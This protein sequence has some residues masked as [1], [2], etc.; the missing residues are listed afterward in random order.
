M[1]T[2][3]ENSRLAGVD[4]TS[5]RDVWLKKLVY[6]MHTVPTALAPVVVGVG[7]AAGDDVFAL[8]SALVVF[9]FGWLVQLGGVLADNYFNLVRYH[10]DAE[11]PA[12]VYAVDN[13][14]IELGEIKRVT[15]AVFVL[16]A[17][18]A[19]Y[20]VAV[21][22]VPVIVVGVASVAV[23]VFYSLEL[24]DV[25]LHDLYFFLFFGP[26]S[27]GGTYYMQAVSHLPVSFPTWLPLGTLPLAVVAAGVP[28][29]AITAAILVVDNVRDLEFDREKADLTLAVVIGERWS[30]VEFDAL[31]ALAYLMPPVLSL[32][33]DLGPW[34]L[35]PLLSLP[36][37]AVVRRQ[38]ARAHTYSEL[39]PMSPRTGRFL[40]LYSVLLAVGCWL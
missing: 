3:D 24:T 20:L 19:T 8:R 14:V 27:V 7:L 12:L 13:G 28:V 38:W 1:T 10:D 22:G 23:S 17:L 34:V 35:L 32:W 21:G 40:V 31:L 16:A 9:L 11:H 2:V 25:P 36:Y 30:R 37:A 29:G 15:V 39:L 5:R 26:I 18:V 33:T 6:P 4:P